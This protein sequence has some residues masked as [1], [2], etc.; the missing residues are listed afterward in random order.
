[1]LEKLVHAGRQIPKNQVCV[2]F[3]IPEELP[4]TIL[5][6]NTVPGGNDEDYAASRRAGDA[7]LVAAQTVI[8]LVPAT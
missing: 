1:M 7:W 2:V 8:L 5:D 4:T 6:P 3:E